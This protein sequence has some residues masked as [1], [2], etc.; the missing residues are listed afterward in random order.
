[1]LWFVDTLSSKNGSATRNSPSTATDNFT[2]ELCWECGRGLAKMDVPP[3][4]KQQLS[5]R[6]S[7]QRL[8]YTFHGRIDGSSFK[9]QCDGMAT[10]ATCERDECLKSLVAAFVRPFL[11][12]LAI[13]RKGQ[14]LPGGLLK[15]S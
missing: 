5:S 8:F 12:S 3:C 9:R 6:G 4:R 10:F 13:G 15:P 7:S 14:P 1:M 11:P 2:K